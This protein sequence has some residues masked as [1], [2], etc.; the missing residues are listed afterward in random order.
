MSLRFCFPSQVNIY[1]PSASGYVSH[2]SRS[3]DPQDIVFTN[4]GKEQNKWLHGVQWEEND[5]GIMSADAI[6]AESL[7]ESLV[8][9]AATWNLGQMMTYCTFF[10]N[11]CSAY[12]DTSA[13][14]VDIIP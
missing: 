8:S 14:F 5:H 1:C 4:H 3:Y 6:N 12:E 11:V 9:Q 7:Q 13:T 2:E 10:P